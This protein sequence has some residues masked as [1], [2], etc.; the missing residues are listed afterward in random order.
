MQTLCCFGSTVG[1]ALSPGGGTPGV[2]G[3]TAVR[4]KQ[5]PCCWKLG[6]ED[7]HLLVVRWGEEEDRWNGGA[8]TVCNRSAGVRR[9]N[10]AGKKVQQVRGLLLK[11]NSE[12]SGYLVWAF[13]REN[14]EGATEP[15]Q[16]WAWLVQEKQ[17]RGQC[18]WS[19]QNRK[20]VGN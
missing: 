9:A 7:S 3:T 4:T 20:A 16:A 17:N 12:A 8:H 6:F 19:R 1:E 14:L 10:E 15:G 2:T 18:G 5:T 11:G 13:Q